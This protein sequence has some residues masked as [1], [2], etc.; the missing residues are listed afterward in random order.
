M[1]VRLAP[2]LAILGLLI[3]AFGCVAGLVPIHRQGVSCGSVFRPDDSAATTADFS[4]A[5]DADAAGVSLGRQLSSASIACDSARS[6][7]K[8]LALGG[9]IPGVLLLAVGLGMIGREHWSYAPS[10][11]AVDH[12]EDIEASDL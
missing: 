10:V 4:T 3:A 8:P 12:A 7:R 9:V 6:D 5:L 2:A 1:T 11:N